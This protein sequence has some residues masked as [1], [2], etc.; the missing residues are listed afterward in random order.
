MHQITQHMSVDQTP[1][2]LV[3]CGAVSQFQ[4]GPA[5]QAL[6]RTGV[7]RVAGLVDPSESARSQLKKIFPRAVSFSDLRDCSLDPVRWLWSSP[8][9]GTRNKAF[10][11]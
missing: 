6:E 2:I 7:L 8:R 11:P 3:G 10:L 1:I 4:Y 5:L 9:S